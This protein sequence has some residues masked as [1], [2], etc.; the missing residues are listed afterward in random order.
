MSRSYYAVSFTFQKPKRMVNDPSQRSTNAG[1]ALFSCGH[2][3]PEPFDAKAILLIFAIA[4][5]DL[6]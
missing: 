6:Q 2:P 5:S 4:L 3:R 1:N